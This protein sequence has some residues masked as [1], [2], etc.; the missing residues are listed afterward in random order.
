M[1]KESMRVGVI[2]LGAMGSALASAILRTGA[3][4][5]V[6]NRTR[7]KSEA[8]QSQGAIVCN[9]ALE[10]I[11]ESKYVVV[12]VSD[13]PAWRSIVDLQNK[14]D[15][16]ANRYIVQLTT[17]TMAQ[18]EEHKNW[19]D[20][21]G[22]GLVDGSIIC[23]PNQIGTDE[24]SLIVAGNQD[25]LDSCGEI[26]SAVAPAYTYLGANIMAPV[27]LGRAL[28]SQALGSLFGAIN[29]AALCQAGGISLSQYSNQLSRSSPILEAEI[30]RICEAIE[31]HNTVNT[32]ASIRTWSEGQSA[33][34]D[35]AKALKI[36]TDYQEVMQEIFQQANE[37]GLGDHDISALIRIFS[38]VDPV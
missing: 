35:V 18:V 6:W 9:S 22:S 3:E 38:A 17:G 32:D 36:N 13:Y 34:V 1:K 11:S 23:F 28:I 7:S 27:V 29:G 26:L 19:I 37:N 25:S 14:R 30:K 20:Q 21:S 16:L 31:S 33:I 15:L 2:G 5:R 10:A 24:A 4:V 12:C 8:L